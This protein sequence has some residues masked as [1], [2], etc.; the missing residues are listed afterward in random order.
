MY[1]PNKI[2]PTNTS[3]ELEAINKIRIKKTETNKEGELSPET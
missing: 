2:I 3:V 1:T